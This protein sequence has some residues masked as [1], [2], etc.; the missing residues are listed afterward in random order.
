M[1]TSS[2]EDFVNGLIES[3]AN[4]WLSDYTLTKT[5]YMHSEI[6]F[7]DYKRLPEII[8]NGFVVPGNKKRSVEI[9][10]TDLGGERFKF[11]HASLKETARDTVFVN[12]F[13][14]GH[15]KNVRRVYR[16]S[17]KKN[18]LLRDHNKAPV[19]HLLGHTSAHAA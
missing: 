12:M 3:G 4:V 18:M 14:R 15:L 13:H 9:I 19:R 16:R 10:H 8:S 5:R 6:D 17:H 1:P 2:R 11:W 7:R